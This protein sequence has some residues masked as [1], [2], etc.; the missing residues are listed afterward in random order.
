MFEALRYELEGRGFYSRR[1]HGKVFIDI[2]LP[3]YYVPEVDSASYGNK[4]QD[5]FL[6]G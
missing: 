4:Y 2:N 6:R 3:V 5:Y 1:C